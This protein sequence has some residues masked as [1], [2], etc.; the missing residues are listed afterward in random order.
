MDRGGAL[1]FILPG[2]L[3]EALAVTVLLL[4]AMRD[5]DVTKVW[6]QYINYGICT[7]TLCNAFH[8]LCA[9]RTLE[10]VMDVRNNVNDSH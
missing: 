3:C 2:P 1:L 6:F 10:N 4:Q 8:G 7:Y 9:S 5:V